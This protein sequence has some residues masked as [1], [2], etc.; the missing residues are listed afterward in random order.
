M[1]DLLYAREA[2]SN[3]G[4]IEGALSNARA[5]AQLR[6]FYMLMIDGQD[7]EGIRK[8]WFDARNLYG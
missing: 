1:Y 6:Q 4:K 8:N 7:K 5:I 2:I 3:S